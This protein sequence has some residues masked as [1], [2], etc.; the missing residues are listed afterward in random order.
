MT[1][2]NEP[3]VTPLSLSWLMASPKTDPIE[4]TE[5]D[6]DDEVVDDED[7]VANG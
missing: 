1:A 2:A 7:A 6:E 4:D 5:T 3:L